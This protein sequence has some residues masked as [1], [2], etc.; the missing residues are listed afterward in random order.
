MPGRCSRAQFSAVDRV[1]GRLADGLIAD[2]WRYPLAVALVAAA[3][4]TR[5]LLL[6]GA[7]DKSPFQTFVVAALASGLIGGLGPGLLATVLGAMAASYRY[8]PPFEDL[9]VDAGADVLR[10]G[11]FMVE[12]LLAAVAGWAVRRTVLRDRAVQRGSD[13]LR[14]L[15]ALARGS[16][17]IITDDE[18]PLVEALSA[19]ELEVLRM[20]LLGLGN[21]Q[22]AA[23]LYLSTN[24]VKTHLAHIYEKLGVHSR[25]EAVARAL[26]LGLLA[27]PASRAVSD[28]GVPAW[29][30]PVAPASEAVTGPRP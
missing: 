18:V 14:R 9:A 21:E 24:T 8:L 23:R 6:P 11:L 26:L 25:T 17:S 22:I 13:Q 12:G 16:R 20:L 10:L 15:H 4:A 19:R 2:V 3:Y 29:I 30:A 27:E 28:S 1:R 5:E 7:G